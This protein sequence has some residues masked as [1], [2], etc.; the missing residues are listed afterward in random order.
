MADRYGT[1]VGIELRRIDTE[2]IAAVHG[3]RREGFVELD[4]VNVA[5]LETRMLEQ[6][7]NGEHRSN[8]HLVRLAGREHAAAEE[9]ERT[10]P[11]RLG[12]IVRHDE[13]GGGAVGELRGVTGRDAAAFFE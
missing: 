11:Q 1:A 8:A 5:H 4:D 7:G 12:T 13:R 10:D 2:L 6:L 3:L 9:P